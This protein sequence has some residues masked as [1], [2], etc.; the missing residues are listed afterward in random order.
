ML[1]NKAI[2]KGAIIMRIRPE[3]DLKDCY[4]E[5]STYCRDKQE[6]IFITKYGHGDLVVM[7]LE[8][9]EMLVQSM[10]IF[11]LDRLLH[12]GRISEISGAMQ[13][14]NANDADR[15]YEQ[16][17][18]RKNVHEI[19]NM[20]P[21]G[22]NEEPAEEGSGPREFLFKGSMTKNNTDVPP[23]VQKIRQDFVKD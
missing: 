1:Y 20:A 15:Y 21:K 2:K 22:L 9:Y 19:G 12:E 7:S 18:A 6:P 3:S 23:A 16:N 4:E 14:I 8:V 11:R 17:E 5:I 13:R 10:D